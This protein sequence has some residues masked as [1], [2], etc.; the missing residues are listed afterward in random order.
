MK[1]KSE[2]HHGDCLDV[3]RA[4]PANSVTAIVT[5]PPYALTAASRNGI[6]RTNDTATPYGRTRLGEKGFMGQTWDGALPSTEIWQEALRVAKP[7]AMLLAFGGT[8]TYH[9]LACAIEDAGWEIRDCLSWCYGVGFPKSL[10]VSKAID[11]AAGEERAPRGAA[12]RVPDAQRT[13]PHFVQFGEEPD[14]TCSYQPTAPATDAAKLWDGYGTALKPSHE[15]IVLAMKPLDGTFAAN[16]QQHGVAGIN[17]DGGRIG[18]DARHNPSAATNGQAAPV[19][20]AGRET[21]GRWPAN[22]ILDEEAAAMLDEMSGEQRDGVAIRHGGVSGGRTSIVR[23]KP[24]GTPDLGYGG[25][26]GAS[27]FFYTAKV[28]AH[29]RTSG[30]RVVNGHPTL[31]PIALMRWLIRL[32]TMPTGTVILDPFMGSGS[33][34]VACAQE[35][36]DFIGIEREAE[37][38]EIARQRLDIQS[39]V[40]MP[41]PEKLNGKSV[42]E[43]QRATAE[44]IAAAKA[45]VQSQSRVGMP[46][47]QA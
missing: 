41:K 3:M 19:L 6:P 46:K 36:V 28:S 27:R 4:M 43:V 2:L 25:S 14:A 44:R 15:P 35:K 39:K 37:Y 24:P 42:E 38:I 32:V 40:G 33:T 17:V 5:D 26:G 10:D 1:P 23:A 9:R 30:G 29:E 13:R 12:Y 20:T 8:R 21:T 7:G 16:A 11:K 47:E 31:K 34:G 22:L 45:R 18:S